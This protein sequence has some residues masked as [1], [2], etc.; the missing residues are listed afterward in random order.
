MY[1]NFYLVALARISHVQEVLE[2]VFGV[3]G[4]IY[5]MIVSAAVGIPIR[6]YLLSFV[7]FDVRH[8]AIKFRRLFLPTFILDELWALAPFLLV[9]RLGGGLALGVTAALIY[10]PFAQRT[11]VVMRTRTEQ[12]QQSVRV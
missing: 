5:L 3:G 10:L 7:A 6:L 4:W 1:L 11:L 9:R 8:L 2:E 12:D